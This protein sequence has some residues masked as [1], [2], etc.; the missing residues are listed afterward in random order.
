MFRADANMSVQQ[1]P[2]D[3]NVMLSSDAALSFRGGSEIP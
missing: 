3:V 1:P 2:I